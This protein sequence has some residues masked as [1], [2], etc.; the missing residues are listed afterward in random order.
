MIKKLLSVILCGAMLFCFAA[1]GKDD[2]AKT[3]RN[4]KDDSECPF[5]N[6]TWERSTE[7]D[8]EY[9]YFSE[10]GEFSYYCGCGSP[11]DDSDLYEKFSYDADTKTISLEFMKGIDLPDTEIIVKEFSEDELIL[12]FDGDIRVFTKSEE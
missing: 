8:T 6:I 10:D 9:I 3:D 7:S 1:C 12:D 11:V 2:T 4:K 5:V